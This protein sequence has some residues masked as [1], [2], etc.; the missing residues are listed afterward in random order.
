M[1]IDQFVCSGNQRGKYRGARSG[2]V[3]AFD[4]YIGSPKENRYQSIHTSVIEP[5]GYRLEVQIRTKEMHRIS[6]DGVAAH[7]SYKQTEPDRRRNR[8]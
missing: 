2:L 5:E 4:D 1:E 3:G 6:E 8:P 7:S